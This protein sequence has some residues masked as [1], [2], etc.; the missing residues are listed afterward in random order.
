MF[1]RLS[2][3]KFD[4]GHCSIP[5]DG[6]SDHHLGQ[7]IAEQRRHFTS[8]GRNRFKAFE[9]ERVRAL[10]G[11]GFDFQILQEQWEN[12]YAELV[13]YRQA[14]PDKWPSQNNR[15]GKWVRGQRNTHG[16][17]KQAKAMRQ[18]LLDNQTGEILPDD[19]LRVFMRMSQLRVNKLNNLG[20]QWIVQDKVTWDESLDQLKAYINRF[21]DSAVPQHYN[22]NPHLGEWVTRMRYQYGLRQKGRKNQLTEEKVQ[23]LNDVG[24][25]WS[26]KGVGSRKKTRECGPAIEPTNEADEHL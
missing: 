15:L 26:C 1:F 22:P 9:S 7:W 20:F 14:N 6:G 25:Q 24:F 5:L 17:L 8:F 2:L 16:Q 11:L 10:V 12:S 19:T 4:H 18:Q 3:Y 23:K 13:Q 21:G